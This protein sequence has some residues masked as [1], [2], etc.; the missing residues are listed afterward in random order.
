MPVDR[1]PH[2]ALYREL[3]SRLHEVAA[4][5]QVGSGDRAVRAALR[6]E[7]RALRDRLRAVPPAERTPR[8]HQLRLLLD[9]CF[10]RRHVR[11]RQRLRSRRESMLAAGR[12]ERYERLQ[13]EVEELLGDYTVSAHGYTLRLDRTDQATLWAH[14]AEV[15]RRIESHGLSWFATSGTLL[16]LVR[17]HGVV[18]YDDDVDLCVLVEAPDDRAAAQAWARARAD[19]AGLI[20]NPRPGRTAKVVDP[21]GGP[22]VDLFPAWIAADGRLRAW[23]WSYGDVA[24]DAV[25]PLQRRTVHGVEISLP[26]DPETVLETNYGPD[27]RVPDPLF[28][29]DWRRARRRFADFV[30]ATEE[31]AAA[32]KAAREPGR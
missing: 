31:L 2:R 3:T 18:A 23:P 22:T 8:W 6:A 1:P 9:V 4:S 21:A 30:T 24:A 15:G 19:L 25:L 20:R 32:A 14:V 16:G 11:V 10:H 27:W 5:G 17:E 12:T 28:A 26:R 7:Y 13:R 29:F